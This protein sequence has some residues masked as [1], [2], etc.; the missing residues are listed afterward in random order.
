[1]SLVIFILVLAIAI[2]VVLYRNNSNSNN[3]YKFINARINYVY[4]KYAPYSFKVIRA[5]VKELGQEYTPRQ[6]AIQIIGFATGAAVVSYLYFFNIIVSIVYA[7]LAIL[8]IPYLTY[9]R[10]K[11]LYSEFIFEQIQVYTTNTIMEFATTQSFV[12]ALEGVY[13]SQ[14][15]EDPVKADVRLMIDMAYENGTIDQ[16]LD[17]M[18][19]KYDFY[20]VRNMHQLFL[21]IT[22]EGS[23]DAGESLENMSQDIDMLVESVYRDRIDRAGFHR[24]F[25]QFGI[26]LYLMVMLV[27]FMLGQKTYNN[28]LELWYVRLLLHGIIWLNTYFL[29]SG[30]KYYNEDVGAE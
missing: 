6:Y 14:V 13:E 7:I 28:M 12:K 27:Q 21:Q 20:I 1:M 24:K 9:L 8:V 11:R 17:Y 30:E 18:N 15:L 22:N 29:L 2:F 23:R 26:I 5:K 10:C 19:S 25:L 4:E 16:S 3:V